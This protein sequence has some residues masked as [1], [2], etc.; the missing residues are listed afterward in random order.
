M[1][2]RFCCCKSAADSESELTAG[3]G[4]IA[5]QRP[6]PGP[7]WMPTARLLASQPPSPPI[8]RP[9]GAGALRLGRSLEGP[10]CPHGLRHPVALDARRHGAT[11]GC[12]RLQQTASAQSVTR[13]GLQVWR[14][15]LRRCGFRVRPIAIRPL[16]SPAA[17][18]RPV[19]SRT[20]A[21]KRFGMTRTA[22][23]TLDGR[24]TRTAPGWGRRTNIP[25][26]SCT[27]VVPGRSQMTGGACQCGSARLQQHGLGRVLL[28]RAGR[29]R[30]G[31]CWRD[32][33]R[34]RLR[35]RHP[36]CGPNASS[37]SDAP[38]TWAATARRPGPSRW[39]GAYADPAHRIMPRPGRRE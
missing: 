16:R 17:V 1:S 4:R 34:Q 9:A 22:S 6:R 39:S 29:P 30:L 25:R 19:R 8:P 32:P 20:A 24:R 23:V 33:G 7:P 2:A 31:A 14:L 38:Q 10:H 26:R 27:A 15:G 12:G 28:S 21:R 11:A 35:V 37:D 5:M 13:S 18:F 3:Q 36:D